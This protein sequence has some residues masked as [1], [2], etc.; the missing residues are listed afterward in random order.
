MAKRPYDA[1]QEFKPFERKSDS[2]GRH[3]NKNRR[4]DKHPVSGKEAQ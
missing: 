1:T 2:K 4:G 3:P